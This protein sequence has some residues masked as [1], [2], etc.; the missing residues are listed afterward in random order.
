MVRVLGFKKNAMIF[1]YLFYFFSYLEKKCGIFKSED[2]YISSYIIVGLSLAV[3]IFVMIDIV[4][5]FFVHSTV[6]DDI[7]IKIMP[8]IGF[9]MIVLSYLFFKHN[10]RRDKIYDEIEQSPAHKKIKYGIFCALYLILSYVLWFM[11]N[12]IVNKIKNG[13]GLT[14][15]EKIVSVFNLEYW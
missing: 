11:C 15:A 3:N 6:V 2:N 7:I 4:C 9:I 5:I 1:R 10:N 8:I 14:Y 12:D 13:H